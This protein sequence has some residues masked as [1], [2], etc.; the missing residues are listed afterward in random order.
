MKLLDLSIKIW[1]DELRKAGISQAQ[2]RGISEREV[3]LLLFVL[4][5]YPHMDIK[6]VKEEKIINQGVKLQA[7]LKKWAETVVKVTKVISNHDLS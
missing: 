2:Y 7:M 3:S 1:D 5:T 4:T 6:N